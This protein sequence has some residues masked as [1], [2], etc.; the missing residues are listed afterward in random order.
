LL[1][2][3][4]KNYTNLF[5]LQSG[6][7]MDNTTAVI[8]IGD[9]AVSNGLHFAAYFNTLTP[10]QMATWIGLAEQQWGDMFAG[11]YYG[12]EPGGIMLDDHVDFEADF[13]EGGTWEAITKHR[14][15]VISVSANG[16]NTMY[17]PDGE[18]SVSKYEMNFANFGASIAQPLGNVTSYYPNGTITFR[19]I[20]GDLFTTEN[21]SGYISQVESYTQVLARHP[22]QTVMRWQIHLLAQTGNCLNT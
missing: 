6:P 7:L 11:L 14:G 15:G 4:V 22:S 9:Y 13:S 21:G 16:T 2:D 20:G 17:H 10:P 5:V 18:V 19:E 3:R 1:V 12:D 8:E